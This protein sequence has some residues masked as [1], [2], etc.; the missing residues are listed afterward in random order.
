MLTIMVRLSGVQ[1]QRQIVNWY[2]GIDLPDIGDTA[3]TVG[4]LLSS[5]LY[6]QL[7]L[8]L[9]GMP[10]TETVTCERH[11]WLW[12]CYVQLRHSL[13]ITNVSDK[14]HDTMM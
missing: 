1:P 7:S 2:A 8:H 10:F 11:V 4:V 13:M 3:D 9:T 6:E 12:P 14:A 5:K